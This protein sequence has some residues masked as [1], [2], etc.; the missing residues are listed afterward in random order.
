MLTRRDFLRLTGLASTGLILGA[1]LFLSR[2][3]KAITVNGKK[4][5]L[6]AVFQR[7]A[8]D[9]LM[10]V[11]PLDN[12]L[13][14]KYR[15]KL[16]MSGSSSDGDAKLLDLDNQFGFHPAFGSF[17]PIYQQGN[18]A[19]IHC[20]G[21]PDTTRS[22]FDAQDYMEMGTPGN[23]GTRSGWLNRTL[24]SSQHENS[25]FCAVSVTSALP[26]SFYGDEPALAVSNLADFKVNV[27]GAKNVMESTGKSFEALYQQTTQNLLRGTGKESFEATKIIS[28]LDVKNYQP[29]ENANYPDSAFGKSMKQIAILIK[30]NVGLEIAFTEHGGWDTHVQQGTMTGQFSRNAKDFSDSI[31]AFW[32][33]LGNYQE[34]V[35]LLTMTEFGRT[36]RENGSGGTDH[37]HGS[38]M[39]L[40]GHSVLGGKVHGKFPSLENDSLNE[41]RDLPVTTDFR[42]VFSEV[43]GSHLGI[44]E[45]EKLFPDWG[46]RRVKLFS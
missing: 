37:G 20:V 11:S 29:A 35:V 10:A 32:I 38:C 28:K 5:I 45:P 19:V 46:G 8:M 26:K 13:L 1:P 12:P 34:D 41:G 6:V 24:A 42:S 36:V 22:H 33:D 30:N 31:S 14:K 21:S 9:G 18:L 4:K 40:L 43:A 7:G 23:K 25:P 44:S 3:V 16:A 2:T 17:L 39:F 27:P 15:P